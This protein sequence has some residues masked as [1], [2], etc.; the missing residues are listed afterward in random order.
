MVSELSG[1][2]IVSQLGSLLEA[3]IETSFAK[4]EG[5]INADRIERESGDNALGEKIIVQERDVRDIQANMGRLSG[6]IENVRLDS[7]RAFDLLRKE[8]QE[9]FNSLHE[10]QLRES[11]NTRAEFNLDLARIREESRVSIME[12]AESSKENAKRI[13][14]VERKIDRAVWLLV[15]GSLTAGVSGGSAAA[16]LIQSLSG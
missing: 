13:T 12:E 3:K 4:I 14:L 10:G 11:A 7:S 9:G 8:I 6:T 15:G 1:H 2:E 5:Q 16:L